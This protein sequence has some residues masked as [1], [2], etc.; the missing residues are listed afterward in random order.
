M[1][2]IEL[3]QMVDFGDSLPEFPLDLIMPY[4]DVFNKPI[5]YSEE[6]GPVLSLTDLHYVSIPATLNE[7]QLEL[8]AEDIVNATKKVCKKV[9]AKERAP[10]SYS[11]IRY[12]SFDVE[13]KSE[14]F[15][16]KAS[17]DVFVI[18][19][20]KGYYGIACLNADDVYLNIETVS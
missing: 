3:F 19:K 8:A 14:R 6:L 20:S 11:V 12:K 5:I 1:K 13:T 2:A 17:N 18:V 7:C 15:S 4:C 10:R 9:D 16:I